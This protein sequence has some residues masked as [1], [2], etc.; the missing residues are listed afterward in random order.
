MFEGAWFASCMGVLTSRTQPIFRAVARDVIYYTF[1]TSWTRFLVTFGYDFRVVSGRS[2]RDSD[3]TA[4][5][6]WGSSVRQKAPR[7]FFEGGS[8]TQCGQFDIAWM[9]NGVIGYGNNL[10]RFG[11]GCRRS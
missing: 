3:V 7:A 6:V 1:A 4:E 10:V 5:F 2:Y 8:Y 11:Y 9:A